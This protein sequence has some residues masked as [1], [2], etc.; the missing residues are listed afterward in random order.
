MLFRRHPRPKGKKIT[1]DDYFFKIITNVLFKKDLQIIKNI[2]LHVTEHKAR[3]DSISSFRKHIG[4]TKP[5]L[6]Y[7]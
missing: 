5:M 2:Y 3:A 7:N 4:K 6:T 1:F